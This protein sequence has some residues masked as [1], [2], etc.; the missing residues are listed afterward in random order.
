MDFRYFYSVLGKTILILYIATDTLY[1]FWDLVMIIV[2]N[3]TD[4]FTFSYI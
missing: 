4:W 2:N 1:T 3:L